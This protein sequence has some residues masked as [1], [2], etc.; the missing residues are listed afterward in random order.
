MEAFNI[1]KF[2]QVSDKI[3]PAFSIL[4]RLIFQNSFRFITNK[5]T[6]QVVLGPV[7]LPLL[8]FYKQGG[9]LV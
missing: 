1:L 5:G 8:A 3:V 9:D 7:P 6:S 4:T 2:Y